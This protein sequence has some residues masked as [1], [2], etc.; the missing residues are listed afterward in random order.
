LNSPRLHVFRRRSLEL[1]R[2]KPGDKGPVPT[3]LLSEVASA[4]FVGPSAAFFD[5]SFK[6]F[7]LKH[8]KNLAYFARGITLGNR[9]QAL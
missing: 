2:D 9:I 7:N 8:T 5:D 1:C 3:K 6:E 4:R